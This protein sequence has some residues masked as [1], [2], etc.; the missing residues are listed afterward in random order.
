M[1]LG[2]WVVGARAGDRAVAAQITE[3]SSSGATAGTNWRE[4]LS[5]VWQYYLPRLPFQQRYTVPPGGYPLLQVWITQAWG[6]FGWLEV[7]FPPWVYRVLGVLTVS[8]FAGGV[9]AL[10]RARRQVEWRVLAFVALVFFALLGGLHW[11]DYHQLESGTLGFMQG[12]YMFPAIGV[13][14]L[15]LGGAVSLLPERRHTG[16]A[17]AAIGALLV[18][19]LFALGLVIDRFYA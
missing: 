7:K 12:R 15:A 18:F 6:A 5:Y 16:A 19:H 8:V 2:A 13:F 11:T 10:V 9:A 17:G 14:G 4:L 3:S 1:T